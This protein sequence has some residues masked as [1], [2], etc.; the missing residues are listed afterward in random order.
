MMPVHCSVCRG[1]E[2]GA[3]GRLVLASIWSFLWVPSS[4]V[5]DTVAEEQPALQWIPALTCA[6]HLGVLGRLQSSPRLVPSWEPPPPSSPLHPTWAQR[7]RQE[8]GK[9]ASV[10]LSII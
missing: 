2:A 1:R 7:G 4:W 9:R 5:P 10:L 3:P 8:A 6:P